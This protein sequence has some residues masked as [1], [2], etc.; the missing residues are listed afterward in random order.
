MTEL[1]AAAGGR[2]NDLPPAW[3]GVPITWHGWTAH[4]ST[5]PLHV[6]AD[7]LCCRKC[8]AVG[9][10]LINWGTRPPAEPTWIIDKEL[11]TK[12]GHRYR[13]PREVQSWPV[14]DIYAARCRHCRHDV[15]TDERTGEVWDLDESDYGPDGSTEKDTLF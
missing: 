2:Q 4:R 11:T 6:P 13:A 14:R 7:A 5:L 3:D 12:S 10:N 15:V 8:G 1:H 9:E